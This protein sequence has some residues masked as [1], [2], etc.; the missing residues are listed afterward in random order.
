[1]GETQPAQTETKILPSYLNS[2]ELEK[3]LGQ[4]Q[5]YALKK[6]YLLRNDSGE[7]IETVPEAI[8]R[9]AR[10]MASVE[11]NYGMDSKGIESLTESFY[12]MIEEGSFS[13]AGRIW[14]NAGT[15][16]G[17]LFNCYVLPVVDTMDLEKDGSIFVSLSKAAVIHKNGGGTGYNFSALRPRGSYVKTSKG[18]A[19]GPVSFIGQFDKE[20]EVINSGNRRG[21]N[22]GILDINH[23]DIIDFITAKSVRGKI[24]N[25]NIS[26]GATDD[27]M[28]AVEK[29]EFYTLQF[30]RG[31]PFKYDTLEK[32]V[33]NIEE[34]KIGGSDVG[35]LPEPASLRLEAGEVELGK[36]RVM[37]SYTGEVAG[38][39]D[40]SGAVQLSASYVFNLITDLAHKT[41]DPGMIFLDIINKDN[42][43]PGLGPMWATNPCGEQ[44][45][46][47]YDACNL[48]SIIVSRMLK[49]DNDG[50]KEID[51]GKL[52]K[53]T[54]LATRFMDNVNDANRGPI[55]E[56]QR[57]VLEHRRIGMGVMSWADA[58]IEMGVSYDSEEARN[59]AKQVMGFITDIAKD[60][61]VKLASVKGVF[62]AFPGSIYDNEKPEDR[63]RNVERT[64][65]AP[66]GTISMV[67]NVSSGI[68]PIFAIAFRKNIRGGDTLYYTNPIFEREMKKRGLNLEEFL[69]LI[70]KNHGSIQ[71]IEGIPKDLQRIFKTAYDLSYEEHVLMQSAFQEKTDNAVS[72]T[73]NMREEATQEDVRGAYLLAWKTGTKGITIYRDGSKDVQVLETGKKRKEDAGSL[74]Q[75]VVSS[76]PLKVPSIMPAI[77]LRQN[78]PYGNIHMQVIVDPKKGYSPLEV[79]AELGNGGSEENAAMEAYGRLTSLALREG[80][81]IEKI[82]AQLKDIGSGNTPDTTTIRR[83]GGVYSLPMAFAKGLMKFL[84]TKS[85]YDIEDVFLGRIDYGEMDK[86]ISDFIRTGKDPFEE[87]R[88]PEEIEARKSAHGKK[89]ESPALNNGGNHERKAFYEKC[90]DCGSRL[91]HEE[92]CT[93]C[94]NGCG[95]SRC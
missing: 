39:V 3:K 83:D 80:I 42:P 28:R 93:K 36:T 7:I 69:P 32:I 61:S 26:V 57:T 15:D 92:G 20:T 65:I 4:N 58:L 41:G 34:N 35:A 5:I 76:T 50:K 47:P 51:Y 30:P 55:K 59:L 43:L 9:M 29:E 71:G 62:P 95:F 22:M 13:P 2:S 66:T 1:M 33:R 85:L 82:I 90:P 88:L 70:D 64:T 60:E 94:L 21:A 72:K 52:E 77:K 68:E 37:N 49:E 23:P 48:G 56:V 45:L 74:E 84:A 16:I 67:Y 14:T 91:I 12:H 18:I 81:P 11:S 75:L 10:T 54:R 31:Q 6:K 89:E 86:R 17:G 44:P 73:I 78:T 8:H 46:H 63:V 79:F 40:E 25:F 87:K 27:F 24:T 38:R 19:S 53:T